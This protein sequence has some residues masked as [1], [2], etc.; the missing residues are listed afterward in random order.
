MKEYSFAQI[1]K[2][3]NN[4]F[5]YYSQVALKKICKRYTDTA[6]FR[7]E[8]DALLR[9]YNNGGHPNISGLRDMYEDYDHY[10]Q[11]RQSH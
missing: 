6:S 8:T 3:T 2:L 9:I 1:N 4:Y 7:N 5:Y 10:F 11:R